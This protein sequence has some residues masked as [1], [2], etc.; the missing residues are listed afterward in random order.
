MGARENAMGYSSSTLSGTWSLYNN[1]AG[2]AGL[3]NTSASFTY[4]AHPALPGANRTAGAF[5]MPLKVGT[6]GAGVYTFGDDVY[7]ETIISAGYANR[8]GLAALGAQ[9]NYIQY[10]TEG[11]GSKGVL[12]VNVGGIAE[13]TPQFLVAAYIQNINQPSINEEDRLPTKLVAGL[14]FK[15]TEKFV[16]TTEIEKDLDYDPLW[17]MGLEYKFHEKFF[18]RTGFNLNPNAA[19]FGLGFKAK[20]FTIDYALQHQAAQNFSHQASV[21]YQFKK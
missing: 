10:R 14:G 12:S 2:L 13:L 18:A 20:K 16:L 7:S 8:F 11:F 19:F 5:A 4:D 3:K 17:K 15:P 6:I 1:V 21:M 9:V